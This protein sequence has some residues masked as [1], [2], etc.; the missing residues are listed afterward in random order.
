MKNILTFYL[1]ILVIIFVSSCSST[2][3][4]T[5]TVT[6]PAPVYLSDNIQK[7]AILDRSLPN[8]E[9]KI[10]DALD[11]ILTAEGKELDKD[12]AKEMINGLKDELL[13]RNRF[14]K[15]KVLS[16]NER[17]PG[18]GVFPSKLTWEKVD[19]LC[20]MNSV[21]ALYVLSFYDT[22]AKIDYKQI[23]VEVKNPLGG[24]IKTV[25]HQA[26]IT[27][28]IKCG[29]RIYDNQNKTIQDEFIINERIVSQGRGIN[30]LKA[31]KAVVDRK[32]HVMDMSN[33]MGHTYAGRIFNY[34]IR[35]S[36]DYYVRGT[37]NFKIAKRRAQTGDWDGAADLWEM[38]LT[39]PKMKVAG[40]A[41]YNMAI[42]NEINGNLDEALDWAS[43]AYTDYGDK[44]ALRYT[45]ILKSRIQKNK[46]L[47]G[48]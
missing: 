13:D 43:K 17:S 6:E 33:R 11:K 19:Q 41:T 10:L 44:R 20:K 48:E 37:D 40:R 47:Y 36:R 45:N 42:I 18:M 23:P 16:V 39:N 24:V 30:P 29:W 26:T 5:M 31:I 28:N 32:E 46:L 27:T 4:L 2:N 9:T 7:I 22:D 8:E 25:E 35:V 12:G 1:S 3:Y 15:I 38:E 34:D 14:S 21:D